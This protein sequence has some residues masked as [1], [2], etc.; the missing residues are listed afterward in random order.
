MNKIIAIYGDSAAGKTTV[1]NMIYD[2]LVKQGARVSIPKKQAGTGK[3]DFTSVL[4]YKNKKVAI[5]SMGDIKKH[6]DDCV[7][8]F[9]NCDILITAYN[10]SFSNIGSTWLDNA[11]EILIVRKSPA[12]NASPTAQLASNT[13]TM[14]QVLA[15]LP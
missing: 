4:L 11:D 2:E 10:N 1:C 13:A 15:L 3:R 8:A 12:A 7:Q 6:V 5:N 14:N 9:S